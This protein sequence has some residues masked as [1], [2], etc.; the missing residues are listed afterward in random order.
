MVYKWKSASR[1]KCDAQI[2]GE[3]LSN[4]E[5]TVGLTPKKCCRCK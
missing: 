3:F 4:I 5:D 1:I 2:A